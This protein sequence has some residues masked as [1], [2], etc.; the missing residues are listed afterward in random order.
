M[1]YPAHAPSVLVQ[2]SAAL[3]ERF[4]QICVTRMGGLPVLNPALQVE[5]VDFRLWP[6]DASDGPGLT[7]QGV[8]LGI[9]VTPWFMNLIRLP[10]QPEPASDGV[11]S[12]RSQ[13]LAGQEFEFIGAHEDGI[14][15]FAACSLFSPMFDFRDPATARDTAVLILAHLRA[16]VAP[17]VARAEAPAKPGVAARRAFLLGR[18]AM[19]ER[20]A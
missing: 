15:A 19:A 16:P 9:L 4:Q 11:G 2:R 18:R 5:V 20:L 12:K 13:V 3:A 14:G 1:Q 6:D 7:E 17:P 10:L 8:G